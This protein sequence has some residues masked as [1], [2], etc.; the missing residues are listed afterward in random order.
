MGTHEICKTLDRSVGTKLVYT[1]DGNAPITTVLV[2]DTSWYPVLV[3]YTNWY[4]GPHIFYPFWVR[5]TNF[6]SGI[7]LL[8][9]VCDV[10]LIVFL[11][12]T[13]FFSLLKWRHFSLYE[14]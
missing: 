13:M 9:V 5:Y 7:P 3:R 10:T 1:R 12:M 2:R 14:E 4:T 11:Q 8:F 6:W